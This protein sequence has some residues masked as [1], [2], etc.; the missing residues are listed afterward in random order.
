MKTNIPLS[1]S[2]VRLDGGFLG[3]YQNIAG[4]LALPYQWDILNDRIE[5]VPPNHTVEN[6][7]IAAGERTGSFGGV[8]YQDT[9]LSKWLDAVGCWLST[10]EDAQLRATADTIIQ[11]IARAQ[12]ADGYLDTYYQLCCPQDRWTDEQSHELYCFGHMIEAGVSFFESTGKDAL[13]QVARR[14]ADHLL[15][16]FGPEEGKLHAY[17]G[18]EIIEMALM[19]LYEAT[20]HT[21]YRD[22][23]IYLVRQRA[24]HPEAFY[25]KDENKGNAADYGHW[26]W[27]SPEKPFSSYEEVSGHA[28]RAMYLY[29]GMADVARETQDEALQAHCRALYREVTERQMYITGGIG[30]TAILEAYTYPYDLPNDTLYAETC[31]SIG[32]V[33]FAMRMLRMENHRRYGDIIEKVIYNILPASLSQDGRH[34]FYVNPLEMDEEACR[35]SPLKTHV[36]AQRQPWFEC[37]CCPPNIARLLGSM[38]AYFYTI[39]DHRINVHQY[40][41]STVELTLPVGTV[42][43]TQHTQYPWDGEI[44]LT[45][46][47]CPEAAFAVALRIPGWCRDYHLSVGGQS[48]DP[49]PGPDGYC[50]LERQ[51][52]AGDQ[53]SLSLA[54]SPQWM[55]AHTKVRYDA[56]KVALQRGPVVYCLEEMDNGINLPDLAVDVSLSLEEQWMQD[57][58]GFP[59]YPALRGKGSRSGKNALGNDALYF[60]LED[61]RENASLWAVPYCLWGERKPGGEMLVWIRQAHSPE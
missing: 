22:L 10:H 11:T 43:I 26:G 15:I 3:H 52:A 2:Q 41:P 36:Q 45:L 54:I 6:F 34:Y 19:R 1:P 42:Q 13:L 55:Q 35:K 38:G 44:V 50:V 32:L 7:Q 59:E 39:E 47:K 31:A 30:S 40:A 46:E 61:T 28:V 51:W 58:P 29:A 56:G 17:R 8:P 37:A 20:G 21:P 14:L 57:V 12:S 5:G 18:H 48:M 49:T 24:E 25:L 23:A 33:F 16:H 53:I 4:Q 60:P 27:G 9:D